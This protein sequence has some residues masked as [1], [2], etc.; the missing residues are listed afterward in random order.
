MRRSASAWCRDAA[1]AGWSGSGRLLFRVIVGN[2]RDNLVGGEAGAAAEVCELYK[3]RDA[4]DDAARILD[5]LAHGACG[6]SCSEEIVSDEDAGTSRDRVG[7]GFQG[8][9]AV[10]ELVGG[11]DGLSRE[12]VRFTGEDEALAGTV[13]QRR[14]EDE[15]A[16]LGGE[17][18]VVVEAVG[19]KGEGIHGS[20]EGLPILY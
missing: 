18:A 16:G 8:V 9:C 15:A 7:M 17:D 3:E 20:V 6:A 14:T 19:S 11:R 4:G 5:E 10:L 1:G 12:L 2:E 13:G